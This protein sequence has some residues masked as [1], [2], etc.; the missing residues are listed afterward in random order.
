[1]SDKAALHLDERWDKLIDLSFRRMVYGTLT[2]AATAVLLFS[3]SRVLHRS[4]DHLIYVWPMPVPMLMNFE[5]SLSPSWSSCM[6][7]DHLLGP[8][9]LL[10][11]LGRG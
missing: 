11:G 10:L 8:L 2:G 7:R 6:Q 1:M 5:V 4:I 9:R 3:E